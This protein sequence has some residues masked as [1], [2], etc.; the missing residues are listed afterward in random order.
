M[1]RLAVRVHRRQAELVLAQLLELAPSGVEEVDVN[2]EVVEYAVY[3]APGELPQVPALRAAAGGAYVDIRTEEIADDWSERWRSFH[4]PLQ[5]GGRLTV[6]PPW[7]PPGETELDVVIDPGQAFGTGAHATT[8]LCLELMLDAAD[9]RGDGGGSLV[10]VGCGSGVLAIV[11][12]KLGFAPVTALDLDRAAIAATSE[13]AARNGVTVET[14]LLDMRHEQVPGADLVVANVLAP[15]LIAWAGAQRT[16]APA[17]IL[18]G[19]LA[20]EADRV[21]EAFGAHGVRELERR[22]SGEWAALM[23]AR[24]SDSL[25]M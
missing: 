16:L 22:E 9:R 15:P 23:L 2:P 8:R 17:L 13:N 4:R 1:I 7:E 11:A 20:G 6:R 19:L 12:A 18:S 10:D 14:R 21:A 3:G 5:I 24:A 25:P